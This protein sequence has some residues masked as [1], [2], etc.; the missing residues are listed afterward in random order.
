ME[1]YAACAI[2]S[3]VYLTCFLSV[4]SSEIVLKAPSPVLNA[5]P[6]NLPFAKAP[7]SWV[8]LAILSKLGQIKRMPL[9]EID[10]SKHSKPQRAMKILGSDSIVGVE[11]LSGNSD[12]LVVTSAGNAVLYNENDLTIVSSKAGG[13]KSISGLN[14]ATASALLTFEESDRTK[15]LFFTDKSHVKVVDIAKTVVKTGRLNKPTEVVSS[16]K[17]DVHKVVAAVKYDGSDVMNLNLYLSDHSS[18]LYAMNEFYL[19]DYLNAKK[20][21]PTPAKTLVAHVFPVGLQCINNKV[22][23]HEVANK[24]S[25]EENNNVEAAS[26][27]NVVE[28][29]PTD[30]V[31]DD[32][33]I[34]DEH[35]VDEPKAEEK[36]HKDEGNFEQISIFD[37]IDD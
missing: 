8:H 16:F 37:D 34:N 33:N 7:T 15:V 6:F 25:L 14:N 20:N 32:S 9:S 36:D 4:V 3:V 29:N 27:S 12:I 21:I 5:K 26:D 11:L 22:I 13:V 18:F 19:T 1:I 24:F 28:N 31:S 2:G 10:L 23:S 17:N 35:D 30:N